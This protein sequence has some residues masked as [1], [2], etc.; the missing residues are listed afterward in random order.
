MKASVYSAPRLPLNARAV[1]DIVKR[2]LAIITLEEHNRVG[3][4]GSAVAEIL[5]DL[6]LS[7]RLL[8][9]GLDETFAT[10]VGD[11]DYLRLAYGLNAASVAEAVVRFTQETRN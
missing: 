10:T 7:A 1:A 9:L 8:R 6:G 3:A 5:C 4:L 2:S 11:A